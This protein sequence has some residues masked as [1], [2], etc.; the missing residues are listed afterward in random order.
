MDSHS[1]MQHLSR[2]KA[3]GARDCHQARGHRIS[4]HQ[5]GCAAGSGETHPRSVVEGE[6]EVPAGLLLIGVAFWG[7]GEVPEE[8]DLAELQTKVSGAGGRHL[9]CG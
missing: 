5:K 9:P 3:A 8:H 6:V 7:S 4:G 2:D 1:Q